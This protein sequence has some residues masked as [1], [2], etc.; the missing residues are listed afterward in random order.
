MGSQ[1]DE[2]TGEGSPEV[3][4]KMVDFPL[5]LAVGSDWFDRIGVFLL[6]GNV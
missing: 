2:E 4:L 3:P 1:G 6:P 5:L